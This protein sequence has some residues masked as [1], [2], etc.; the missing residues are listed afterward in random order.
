VLLDNHQ[1]NC[2]EDKQMTI[3]E[4]FRKKA[5]NKKAELSRQQFLEQELEQ[6]YQEVLLPKMQYL[7]D[8]INEIIKYLNFL[9]EPIP[10]QNYCDRYPQLGKLLQTDYKINTDG[11]AGMA[12]YNRLMQINVSFFCEAEGTFSYSLTSK[13]LIDKE[14][15]FLQTRGLKFEQKNHNHSP[16]ATFIVQRKIPV[17]FKIKVDYP[18]SK[19][20]VTIFNHENFETFKK[21]FTAEQLDD[22]FL[23]AFLS[24]FLRRD[25]RFIKPDISDEQ[26]AAILTHLA[27]YHDKERDELNTEQQGKGYSKVI[28]SIKKIL[29]KLD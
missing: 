12:E 1:N 7:F 18:H 13:R 3:L 10:I 26:K 2:G 9:E 27:A 15:D 8:N 20:K 25:N 21:S 19:L 29:S 14:Y 23:D 5:N 22:E 24:Y 4:E 28:F 17:W 6:T 16:I 11:Y